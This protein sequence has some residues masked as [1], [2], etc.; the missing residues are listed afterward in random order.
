MCIRD[1]NLIDNSE[2]FDEEE[3]RA[4]RNFAEED[5]DEYFSE[6]YSENYEEG[7]E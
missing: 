3:G 4:I 7:D 6:E 1:S 2:E 5:E